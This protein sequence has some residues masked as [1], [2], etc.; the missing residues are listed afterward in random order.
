M[1]KD[2]IIDV[3]DLEKHR[4]IQIMKYSTRKVAL[5]KYEQVKRCFPKLKYRLYELQNIRIK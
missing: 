2:Y 3:Y 5:F 4:W 1:K